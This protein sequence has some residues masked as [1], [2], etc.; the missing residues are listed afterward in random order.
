MSV[1]FVCRSLPC[2]NTCGR[3]ERP[4]SWNARWT[5][6]AVCT[7]SDPSHSQSSIKTGP[8]KGIKERALIHKIGEDRPQSA[9]FSRYHRKLFRRPL[10][11]HRFLPGA[12]SKMSILVDQEKPR[13]PWA[14]GVDFSF[15]L[16][17]KKNCTV[18]IKQGRLKTHSDAVPR[19]IAIG[20]DRHVAKPTL[21]H[22]LSCG[23]L[24]GVK[25]RHQ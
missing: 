11:S 24:C 15:A 22:P 13:R 9:P 1:N 23:T 21:R 14:P 10:I 20:T 5:R 19:H 18:R 2:Q 4:A 12:H 3:C 17:T 25:R 8:V 7:G 6:N 16:R